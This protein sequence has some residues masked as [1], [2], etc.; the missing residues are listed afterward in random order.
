MIQIAISPTSLL[1]ESIRVEI[2][3]G[4]RLFKFTETLQQKFEALLTK[5][6]TNSLTPEEERELANLNELDRFFTYLN[7]RLLAPA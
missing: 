6:E 3:E 1:D 4:L 7:A 2:I 5:N